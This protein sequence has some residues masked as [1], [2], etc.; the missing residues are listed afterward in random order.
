MAKN[1]RNIEPH[2]LVEVSCRAIASRFLL[3]PSREVNEL[4]AGILA[5]AARLYPV[6]VVAFTFLSSHY[7]GLL[8][9]ESPERLAEFMRYLNSNLAL[10]MGRAHDWQCRF[11]G[12]RYSAIPVSNEEQAQVRRMKYILAAGA[13]EQLVA[14]VTDW[15]GV[16]CA[17]QLLTDTPLEGIWIDRT[18]E[19]RQR[20]SGK[21]VDPDK[22]RTIETLKFSRLPC[23]KHLTPESYRQR[24]SE[25]VEAIEEEARAVRLALGT[26]VVGKKAILQMSPHYA[27][28]K[29]KRSRKPLFFAASKETRQ[30]MYESFKAFLAAY[31]EASARLR[32]GHLDAVFPSHCFPPALPF[33]GIIRAGP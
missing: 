13:K 27:P 4:I 3:K 28:G 33:T 19:Y 32:D 25:L 15:P 10:E 9:V 7:H 1:P 6:E 16:H 2:S 31:T 29:Q 17:R 23:W 5:R 11:W 14:R 30:R 18:F 20:R 8:F 26:K 24:I 21:K 12:D 22:V